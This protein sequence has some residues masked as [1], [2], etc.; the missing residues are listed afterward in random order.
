ML[1]KLPPRLYEILQLHVHTQPRKSARPKGAALVQDAP[2]VPTV[3]FE[4]R[5]QLLL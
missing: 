4:T 1:L 5:K 2:T 3:M